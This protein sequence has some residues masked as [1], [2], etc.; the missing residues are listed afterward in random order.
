MLICQPN[1][2][3]LNS[4]AHL[5][6]L[7]PLT[8]AA[9]MIRAHEA[10]CGAVVTKTIRHEVAINPVHHIGKINNDSLI[11]CEKWADSPAEVW[12]ERE[13][14]MAKRLDVLLLPAWVIPS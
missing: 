4:K 10:G 6:I 3:G 7:G 8:Y 9:G 14:P 13:I 12:F 1:F 2:A 5:F 11:N